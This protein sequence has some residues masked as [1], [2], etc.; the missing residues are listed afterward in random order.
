MKNERQNGN[1]ENG[2]DYYQVFDGSKLDPG[3]TPESG[4]EDDAELA[5]RMENHYRQEREMAPPARVKNSVMA[6]FRAHHAKAATVNAARDSRDPA[7]FW[8]LFKTP[9]LAFVTALLTLTIGI[10]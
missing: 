6:E 8:Q 9:W 5:A 1:K 3:V 4:F 2:P 7:P 10:G